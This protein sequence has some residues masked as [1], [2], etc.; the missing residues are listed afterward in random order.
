MEVLKDAG[1]DCCVDCSKKVEVIDRFIAPNAVRSVTEG[2][3]CVLTAGTSA[4]ILPVDGECSSMTR[5]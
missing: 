4:I 2:I 1:A 5:L 3:N